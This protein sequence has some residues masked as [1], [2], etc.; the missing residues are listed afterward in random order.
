MTVGTLRHENVLRMLQDTTHKNHVLVGSSNKEPGTVSEQC[1]TFPLAL[2]TIGRPRDEFRGALEIHAIGLISQLHSLQRTTLLSSWS[3]PTRHMNAPPQITHQH[4]LIFNEE[5]I[6]QSPGHRDIEFRL[7]L[8]CPPGFPLKLFS[9]KSKQNMLK[10]CSH[11]T[12][13]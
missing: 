8:P 4:R 12:A 3:F 2:S 6:L 5:A 7:F 1:G 11:K 9:R 10:K 13:N